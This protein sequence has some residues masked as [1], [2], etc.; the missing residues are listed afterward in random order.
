MDS[1]EDDLSFVRAKRARSVKTEDENEGSIILGDQPIVFY[2]PKSK[3]KTASK[4]EVKTPIPT[5]TPTL[6]KSQIKK[7]KKKKKK[8]DIEVIQKEEEEDKFKTLYVLIRSF[9]QP[10]MR[11]PKLKDLRLKLEA[12]EEKKAIMAKSQKPS[13]S[14]SSSGVKKPE[15]VES[16]AKSLKETKEKET[17]VLKHGDGEITAARKTVTKQ[18]SISGSSSSDV[19]HSASTEEKKNTRHVASGQ[20]SIT[21]RKERSSVIEKEE[22]LTETDVTL[23][24]NLSVK[25]K[26]PS[27]AALP[28]DKIPEDTEENEK[29][30]HS[31]VAIVREEESEII[32]EEAK[33]DV[34]RCSSDDKMIRWC[35]ICDFIV[36]FNF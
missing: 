6:D 11:T 32:G 8:K 14:T 23:V 22:S 12:A 31:D 36:R 3:D 16:N 1:S 21:V 4:I 7:G 10:N 13:V 34:T 19:F 26:E 24:G 28:T 35:S 5:A 29:M 25:E 27:S 15:K 17:K 2:E 30:N 33:D 9:S 20:A 18:K